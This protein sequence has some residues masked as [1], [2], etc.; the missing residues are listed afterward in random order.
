MPV[1]NITL[2]AESSFYPFGM[3]V[4]SGGLY[5]YAGCAEE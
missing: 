3:N 1:Q 5:A 4:K 2:I